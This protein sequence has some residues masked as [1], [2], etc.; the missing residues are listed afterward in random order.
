MVKLFLDYKTLYFD[1]E[2]FMFYVFIELMDGD[3]MYD[4]VGY[5]SKEKVLVDDYNLV[6]ILMLLVY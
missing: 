4:I 3:E 1:V 6:C 2:S 5:F